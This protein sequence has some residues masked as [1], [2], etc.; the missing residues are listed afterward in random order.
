MLN[1]YALFQPSQAVDPGR[2]RSERSS[3]RIG[4][5][6]LRFSAVPVTPENGHITTSAH[7]ELAVRPWMLRN[8]AGSGDGRAARTPTRGI[9]LQRESE[10][11]EVAYMRRFDVPGQGC[12]SRRLLVSSY[13]ARTNAH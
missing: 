8:L 11:R 5:G 4:P 1:V 12:L 2:L 13:C 6:A 3:V 10:H 9:A 7:V